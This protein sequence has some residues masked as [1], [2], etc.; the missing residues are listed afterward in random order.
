MSKRELEAIKGL[1]R[2]GEIFCAEVI[3]QDFGKSKKWFNKLVETVKS[4]N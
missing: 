1:I 4:E 2:R 3:S